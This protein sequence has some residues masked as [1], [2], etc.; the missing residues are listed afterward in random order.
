MK[1]EDDLNKA[2]QGIYFRNPPVRVH[3]TL[4]PRYRDR[5][6]AWSLES[7]RSVLCT[8]RQEAGGQLLLQYMLFFVRLSPRALRQ[9]GSL[10]VERVR[11]PNRSKMSVSSRPIRV[12]EA[13]LRSCV[14][15]DVVVLGSSY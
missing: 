1:E 3:E 7:D 6:T 2:S 4:A 8:G 13:E 5:L 12:W 11:S 14:N 9:T 10:F 15:V